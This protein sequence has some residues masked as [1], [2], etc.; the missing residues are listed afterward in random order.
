MKSLSALSFCSIKAKKALQS[1]RYTYINY[2]N[3]SL[4]VDRATKIE[5]RAKVRV[6]VKSQKIGTKEL[7]LSMRALGSSFANSLL[8]EVIDKILQYKLQ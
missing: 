7:L 3:N 2:L 4:L 1:F 8:L 6:G 5:L